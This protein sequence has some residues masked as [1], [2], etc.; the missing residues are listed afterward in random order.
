MSVLKRGADWLSK[1]TELHTDDDVL[2]GYVGDLKPCTASLVD[3]AGR[4]LPGQSN[5]RTEHT[6]FLFESSKF[7]TLGFQIKRGLL[8]V[9]AGHY[10]E[11]VQE[12]NKWWTYNDTFKRKI[13]ITTKHVSIPTS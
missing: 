4:L 13:V 3:E 7:A 6:R 1:I 5:T 8:I 12:N 11:V 2:V 9:W 10:Y